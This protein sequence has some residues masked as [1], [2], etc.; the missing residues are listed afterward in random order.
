[1][2][3]TETPYAEWLEEL[4]EMIMELKP[5]KVGVCAVSSEGD[6]LTGYYGD[7]GHVDKAVMGYHMTLDAHQDVTIANARE[8]LAA[9]EEQEDEDD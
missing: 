3:V 9:A 8:I 7:C 1:M 2:N 6:V 4:I 5:E